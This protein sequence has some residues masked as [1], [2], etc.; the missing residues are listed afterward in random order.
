MNL[1]RLCNQTVQWESRTSLSDRD[2]GSFAPPVT[3]QARSE[4]RLRD[5]IAKN[6][7]VTTSTNLVTLLQAVEIGDLIDGREVIT[8]QEMVD[9]GGHS[10]GWKAGTR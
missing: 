2:D 10:I 6:G 1:A 7:E 5:V 3:L 9:I 4:A 8:L